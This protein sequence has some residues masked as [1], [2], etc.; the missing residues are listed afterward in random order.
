[1]IS[2]VIGCYFFAVASSCILTYSVY[3]H[4][5]RK[6]EDHIVIIQKVATRAKKIHVDTSE[7]DTWK[8]YIMTDRG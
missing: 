1:M 2:A 4:Q 7:F 6:G 3:T 8:N 5:I